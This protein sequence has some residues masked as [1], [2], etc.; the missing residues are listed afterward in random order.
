MVKVKLFLIIFIFIGAKVNSL[1]INTTYSL[2]KIYNGFNISEN[3]T[4]YEFTGNLV[5]FN[6]MNEDTGIGVDISPIRYSYSATDIRIVNESSKRYF[7]SW[8][9]D[10][11][12]SSQSSN[13]LSFVNICLYWDIFRIKDIDFRYYFGLRSPELGPFFSINWIN[14]DDIAPFNINRIIFSAGLKHSCGIRWDIKKKDSIFHR[15]NHTYI[16]I[17]AGYKNIYGKHGFFLSIQFNLL[18]L[19]VVAGYEA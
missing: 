16:D 11:I 9:T 12:Y 3:K 1:E 4:F 2:F 7:Y 5:N 10:K 18:E 19:F 8:Q 14:I 6:I 13:I 17:E 15:N